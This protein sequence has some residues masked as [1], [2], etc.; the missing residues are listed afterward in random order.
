MHPPAFGSP[1]DLFYNV[2]NLT[3]TVEIVGDR[4]V[5]CGGFS[6]IRRG[7]DW[8][9]VSPRDVAIKTIRIATKDQVEL[10]RLKMRLSREVVS[11]CWVSHKNIIPFYGLCWLFGLE[12][13]S[14]PSMVY[15]YCPA[16]TCTEYL[17]KNLTAD[18]MEIIQ[19]VA[20]G[21][22]YLHS[23]PRA[24]VHGD[25]KASN[26]LMREDG[27][28][29]LADFGLSRVV[30][31]TATGWTTSST[32]GSYRWMAPE[33]FGGIDNEIKVLV[34]VKSDVWAFGCLCLEILTERTPW[35]Q[36]KTNMRVAK[37][38]CES[39]E[40]PPL[41]PDFSPTPRGHILQH[42]WA[43]EP[44][45][46]PTI[47]QLSWA[48]HH[49]D[50]SI[51][52][53]PDCVLSP[54]QGVWSDSPPPVNQHDTDTF[55]L[56]YNSTYIP[57]KRNE[58]PVPSTSAPFMAQPMDPPLFTSPPLMSFDSFLSFE[59]RTMIT[60]TIPTT[61]ATSSMASL[62]LTPRP[63]SGSGRQ[64][65]VRSTQRRREASNPIWPRSPLLG[66]SS[67]SSAGVAGPSMS[68]GGGTG[69][70]QSELWGR[71]DPNTLLSGAMSSPRAAFHYTTPP[72]V[73]SR[74]NL[75]S[76]QSQDSSQLLTA[77]FSWSSWSSQGSSV[78]SSVSSL[79][80]PQQNALQQYVNTTVPAN[81]STVGSVPSTMAS[82]NIA[83]AMNLYRRPGTM[84]PLNCPAGF[85]LVSART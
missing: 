74:P 53:G 84:A 70:F 72:Q 69:I 62:A 38:V 58:S 16:G 36:F 28:P 73:D 48:L 67:L 54:S 10:E 55:T 75:Q 18:K 65:H 35:D 31:E 68:A 9:E 64:P 85:S 17:H 43:Y 8:S 81:A 44:A 20:D 33:L 27:T 21:L 11:W 6:D 56:T 77:L 66:A 46:R 23:Q 61:S 7:I 52:H 45:D 22:I 63:Q 47:S 42:C 4:P 71:D 57:G 30:M 50:P 15:L 80:P 37:A 24:I 5:G 3:R 76:Q 19:Q 60:P 39:R 41:P 79:Q 32:P 40:R 2:P 34:T 82:P 78:M 13:G 25:I 1:D 29:M 26:I 83:H 49:D 14:L 59:P 12:Y 51:W